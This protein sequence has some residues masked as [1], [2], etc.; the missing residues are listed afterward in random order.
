MNLLFLLLVPFVVGDEV[1]PRI[2]PGVDD[3]KALVVVVVVVL[4]VVVV[5]VVPLGLPP[6]TTK[7]EAEE[8]LAQREAYKRME[9]FLVSIWFP[10]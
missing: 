1:K 7:K 10:E 8:D 9:V 4:P 5:V 3:V 6:A 2:Q